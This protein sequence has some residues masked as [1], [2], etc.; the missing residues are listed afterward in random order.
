[1]TRDIGLLF[2]G[3][4]L[5]CA[6]C[7]DHLFLQ[8]YKQLEFQGLHALVKQLSIRGDVTFPAVQEKPIEKKLEFISVF[9]P[10]LK[11]T[12]PRVPFGKE[13]SVAIPP[14]DG[15]PNSSLQL[16]ADELA[17]PQNPWF[18]RNAVNR[19]W[20]VM[21]GRGLVHPLDMHHSANPPSHPELIDLLSNEF[22]A[23]GMDVRWLLREIALTDAYQRSTLC[24]S[25]ESLL[26]RYFYLVANEKRLSAEQL[27]RSFLRAT[28][29]ET[30]FGKPENEKDL[31]A[32][33]QK[34]V[35]ALANEPREAEVDY[36]P[37]VKGALFLLND[38]QVLEL[39]QPRDG[40]LLQRLSV[41]DD[42]QQLVES[43]YLQVF[44]RRPTDVERAELQDYMSVHADRRDLALRHYVWAMLSSVEFCVNH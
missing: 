20:F 16:L 6:Q 36:E 37:T 28:G 21:M 2:L 31:T 12:G 27:L 7:H 30:R 44:S 35:A 42:R 32:L 13:L 40:N 1:L 24:S 39:L 18:V 33:R 38:R 8:D 9:Q 5:Q 25:T 17:S 43:L 41:T 22:V 19:L 23:H 4:D 10:E 14:G 29:E 15:P 34:F 3:V 26:P 11:E